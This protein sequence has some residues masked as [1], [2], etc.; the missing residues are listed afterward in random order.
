MSVVG[1]GQRIRFRGGLWLFAAD[2]VVVVISAALDDIAEVQPE[3]VAQ[4]PQ[5][6]PKASRTVSGGSPYCRVR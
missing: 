3:Y 4:V 1:S 5:V 6:I 2:L